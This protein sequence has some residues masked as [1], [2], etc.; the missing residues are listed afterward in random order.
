MFV[1]LFLV[2]RFSNACVSADKIA[3]RTRLEHHL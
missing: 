2:F 3:S 1:C